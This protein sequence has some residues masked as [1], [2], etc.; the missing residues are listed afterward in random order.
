MLLLVAALWLAAGAGDDARRRA[1][2]ALA[3]QMRQTALSAQRAH[4]PRPAMRRDRRDVESGDEDAV[5]ARLENGGDENEPAESEANHDAEGDARA[6]AA[7]A[8]QLYGALA[9]RLDSPSVDDGS[10]TA[11]LT[12]HDP[13][14][15]R[16][17]VLWRVRDGRRAQLATGEST[18]SGRLRFP[19][20]PAAATSDRLLVTPGGVS[21]GPGMRTQPAP[22]VLASNAPR[23]AMAVDVAAQGALGAWFAR[24]LGVATR[25]ERFSA[26][27]EA[28]SA[29][30]D[31]K[32]NE[33][34]LR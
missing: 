24:A 14:G 33:G 2:A 22:R 1:D 10:V 20:I 8:W 32:T 9:I 21:P 18:A 12:G 19:P 4:A 7:A 28:P 23:A 34:D 5:A 15:P 31:L 26:E 16:P 25:G 17:L 3:A 27:E 30:L 11:L 29:E 13:H 6:R